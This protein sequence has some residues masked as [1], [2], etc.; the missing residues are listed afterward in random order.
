MFH[1]SINVATGTEIV[2]LN[3][4]RVLNE[5]HASIRYEFS[6]GAHGQDLEEPYLSRSA[7]FS[8]TPPEIATYEGVLQEL[9]E[10]IYS[11]FWTLRDTHDDIRVFGV[12]CEECVDAAHETAYHMA[13]Q[14]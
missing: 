5:C 9:N 1:V 8:D 6:P 13:F 11:A 7:L 3:G 4:L 2:T 12:M 10:L 14:R